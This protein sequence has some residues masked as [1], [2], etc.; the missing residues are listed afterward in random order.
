MKKILFIV[1][2]F[3]LC[4]AGYGI[5]FKT[6][7][8]FI[9]IQGFESKYLGNKRT[10]RV[11]LPK[12]YFSS[13][14]YYP[15]LYAHDGQN[16]FFDENNKAK[17]DVDKSV[18]N[19]VN[20]GKIK[21]VVIVGIDHAGVDRIK[22]YTPFSLPN[23]GGGKG[24]LY[25]KFLVEEVKPFIESNFRVKT[26][27][28]DVGTFGSSLG[29]LI[30]L[31]LGIWYSDVFGTIGC[32]SPSFWWGLETNKQNVYKNLDKLKTLKIYI[33]MGYSE[34]GENESNIIYTTREI[35]DILLTKM[36]F[37]NLLYVEDKKG[38][39]N[40]ISWKER[41]P[42]FLIFVLSK[43]NLS[44]DI[45][46]LD[47]DYYPNEWGIG[48]RGFFFVNATTR[49]GIVKTIYDVKPSL[50]KFILLKRGFIEAKE[51]GVGKIEVSIDGLKSYKEVAI[52]E[53]SRKL[54]IAN[55]SVLSKSSNIQFTVEEENSKKTNYII[56][57]TNID[58]RLSTSI[59]NGR[60]TLLKGRFVIDGVIQ[61]SVKQI[62]FNKRIKDYK[63]SL[64]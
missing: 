53:L 21:E 28:E 55:I 18:E 51:K 7:G 9:I 16:I 45:V 11:F 43:S 31:Y 39:H 17:W 30:S 42:N 36:D 33:D 47:L 1:V 5:S 49:D 6:N 10:I 20:Q 37:P 4:F 64:E 38:I 44:K 32:F 24:E 26:N 27:K 59:T 3:T 58:G 52:D 56:M 8:N 29:G 23:Y 15:V 54:S 46:S 40:E 22:E 13:T 14:N 34:S 63:F 25:G 41:I 48:D 60:G 57:F 61:E 62:I 50:D 19:L 12:D 35:N 2:S